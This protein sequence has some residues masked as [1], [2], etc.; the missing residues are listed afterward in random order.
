MTLYVP[1]G[2]KENYLADRKWASRFEE[3]IEIEF[4][5]TDMTDPR[6]EVPDPSDRVYETYTDE[7]S[8]DNSVVRLNVSA[9]GFLPYILNRLFNQGMA[10]G[11]SGPEK[12]KCRN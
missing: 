7:W 1:V 10:I 5:D 6:A 3:I 12:Y 4:T 8:D 2:A 9:P 11:N